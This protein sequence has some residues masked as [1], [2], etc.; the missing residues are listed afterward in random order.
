MIPRPVRADASEGFRWRRFIIHQ[1]GYRLAPLTWRLHL[2]MRWFFKHAPWMFAWGIQFRFV[3]QRSIRS[4]SSKGFDPTD[5]LL[6]VR[7]S[8]RCAHLARA[9]G[10]AEESAALEITT[11]WIAHLAHDFLND[12]RAPKRAYET[13][14]ELII[15]DLCGWVHSI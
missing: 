2:P 12:L 1:I 5:V 11:N 4:L 9:H 3:H 8:I 14:E 15:G 6:S 13:C 10:Y 7:N